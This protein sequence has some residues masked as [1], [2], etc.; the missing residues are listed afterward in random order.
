MFISALLTLLIAALLY[1]SLSDYVLLALCV[2]VFVLV[3]LM[4]RQKHHSHTGLMHIDAIAQKSRIV[5]WNA[6]LKVVTCVSLLILCIVADSVW[7][8]LL[9]LVGMTAVNL[10]VSRIG[11][12]GYLS[13]LTVP[14]IF[15]TLSGLVLLVEISPQPLGLIDIPFMGGYLS[16]TEGTQAYTSLIILKATAAISCLYCLSLS[17]PIYEITGFLRRIHLPSIVVELMVLIYR[18]VFV[19]LDSLYCM[20]TAAQSR[21]G[22]RTYRNS[23]RSFAGIASN[24]LVR[25]FSRASRS[26]DAMEARAYQGEIRFLEQV[27]PI[28]AL[29]VSAAIILLGTPSILLIIERVVL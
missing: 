28:T 16:V 7:V 3:Y 14:L 23:W 11:P 10:S 29:Q 22:Y 27:K 19:L 17:T 21:L 9:I 18:Y 12:M 24:L 26:F 15:I 2:A 25:S 1:G 6:G 13:L 8:S 4:R 5:G 20:N